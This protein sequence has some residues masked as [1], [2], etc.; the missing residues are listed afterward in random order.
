[1]RAYV[2]VGTNL[3]DRWA[4]LALAARALRTTPGVAVVRASRVYETAP[5]G[6][7]QPS[8][9]NA[10][11]EV[12]TAL[13]PER[14]LA[15]LQGAERAAL[16]RREVRWGPRTLDLDLLLQGGAI[17]ATPALTVPHPGL[18]LRRFVL[19]P[20]AELAPD[21]AVPGDGRTVA[22]LLA[23]APPHELAVVGTYPL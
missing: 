11:L 8:Y 13:P 3:G 16:R 2:S 12:E 21:L 6:P 10:V 9:L 14:L 1:M 18:A 17:V 15:A 19:A 20:L 4:H 23:A 7:P 22:A 5:M